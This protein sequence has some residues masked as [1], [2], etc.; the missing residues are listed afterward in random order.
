MPQSLLLST[1]T[2]A[3][4]APFYVYNAENNGG[5]VIVSGE[6][7]IGNIIGYSDTG[8]FDL[9]D[10]P[11]NVVT[12]MKM[13]STLVNNVQRTGSTNYVPDDPLVGPKGNVK[14]APLLDKIQWGQGK[15]FNGK[16]PAKKP[17]TDNKNTNYY[18]GCVATAMSQIMRFHKYPTVGKGT[19]TYTDNLG[20][21]T[22]QTLVQQHSIGQRCQNVV[23]K[24]M[25]MKQKTNKF[26]LCVAWQLIAFICRSCQAE[27]QVLSH[28]Q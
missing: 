23:K 6:S 13:F 28:K 25:L 11:S 3:D 24:T 20:K 18:V 22:H 4:Y 12:M 8:S 9:K 7:S 27:K 1:S 5:F 19:M 10:A 15:P 21:N 26:P 14:V 17:T 2:S 16:M